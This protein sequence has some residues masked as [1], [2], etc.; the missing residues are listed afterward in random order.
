MVGPGRFNACAWVLLPHYMMQP[1][2]SKRMLPA[3]GL[4]CAAHLLQAHA[5]CVYV[6]VHRVH[7]CM[8]VER[9]Y[10]PWSGHHLSVRVEILYRSVYYK[11]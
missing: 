3:D 9:P 1:L 5:M 2:I 11:L 10:M 8:S 7:S 4:T 6:Y